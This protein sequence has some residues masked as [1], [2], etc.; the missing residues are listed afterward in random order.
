MANR[1]VPNLPGSIDEALLLHAQR[2]TTAMRQTGL[3]LHRD[4]VDAP[5]EKIVAPV[6]TNLATAIARANELR[7]K[8]GAHFLQAS[9]HKVADSVT[10][11]AAAVATDQTT[12]N[13]LIT[14]IKADL[15]TH[16]KSATYHDAGPM[17]GAI[18]VAPTDT[19]VANA[20]DLASSVA[21]TNECVDMFHRHL[22][23]GAPDLVLTES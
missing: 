2:L 17:S 23:S 10:A 16:H 1:L 6:A 18:G 8:V 19:A 12:L 15:N 20:T 11:I 13:T 7:T 5:T 4:Y 14:E 21:L 9:K 22:D 3:L